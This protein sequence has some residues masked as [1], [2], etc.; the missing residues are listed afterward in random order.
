MATDLHTPISM[1][2]QPSPASS[3]SRAASKARSRSRSRPRPSRRRRDSSPAPSSSPP[4]LPTPAFSPDGHTDGPTDGEDDIVE[5]TLSPFDP[6]RITPTLHASLVSEILNLRREVESKTKAIDSLELSLDE[7]K[8]ENESLSTSLSQ[9]TRE[10]RSLKHQIQLLEGG[11]SSAM[12]ELARERDEAVENI[13]DVRKKLEQTQ[14]RARSREDEAERTQMLWDRDREAW[15]NERRNLERKVH[16]VEG[17]LKTVLSE[18]AAAQ[19]AGTLTSQHSENDENAKDKTKGSDTASVASSSQGRRRTSMTSVTTEEGENDANYHNVRYSVMSMAAGKA[20]SGLN[21][22]EELAFDEEDEFVSDEDETPASPEALPEERPMSVNSMASHSVASKARKILGLSL[23]STGS[24][25]ADYRALDMNNTAKALQASSVGYQDAGIQYSPPP[26]P[27]T[28]AVAEGVVP[29]IEITPT[30]PEM[31]DDADDEM[32]A[33]RMRDTSTL[34]IAVEMVS[35]ASQTIGS[36]PS[37]PWTPK[38]P[39]TPVLSAEPISEPVQMTS[40]STQT[41]PIPEVESAVAAKST[42]SPNDIQGQ[43]EVP[44]IAI[45]PP[46]SEPPSPRN[47]V[48]LPPQTK[49]VSI[50]T[51]FR[52]F[53]E[54][55]SIAIQTEEIRI[56]Q[57]PVKLPASLLPS[58]IPDLPTR[59]EILDAGAQPYRAP[60]PPPRSAKREQRSFTNERPVKPP[61]AQASEP[62]QAYPGNNDNGPLSDDLVSGL[63]RPF[64]SSSLFAGFEQLSDDDGPDAEERDVFT[65]D[66]LLNR[67][68]A[69]YTLRRGK[70]VNAKSSRPSLDDIGL[71]EIDEHLSDPESRPSDVGRASSRTTQ[72]SG[73]TASS[74]RQTG[75]RKMAMISS[76]TAAHQRTRARSPSEPSLDGSAGSSIA[77]PFPVPIRL[78]SRKIPLTGSDGPPSPT[79]STGRQFSDRGART[80]IARRPT[81]RRVRSAAAM[82]NSDLPERPETLSS[83]TRSASPFAPDSPS[84]RPPPMPFDDI[85][86]PRERRTTQKRAPHHPSVPSMNWDHERQDSTGGVQPTSVVDAIAQTMVGEWMFKYVRRRKSFGMGESKDNW[87]GRNPDEVSANITNSGVRHKRWVWLAPYEGSIMW[88]SKQPTSGPALLGK[89]GRKFAIQSVLDVKDDNPLPKG[90]GTSPPFSRSILVLTPQRALKFTALTIERHYVWLTALSFLSH[91]SMGLHDLAALP[92]APQEEDPSPPPQAALRR[93]PIRDSIRVAKGKPRPMPKGKRSFPSGPPVPE[94]PPA[95]LGLENLNMAADAPHVPRFSHHNHHTR[96]RSNTAP[97]P[98]ALHAIRSFSSQG[99]MATMPSSHSGTTVGSSEPYFSPVPPPP[100]PAGIGSGRSSIS[101]MSEASGR[102]SNTAASNMFD[103]GTVRMEAFIDHHAEQIN[104]PRPAPSI[105]PRHVRKTSSQWS[106]SQGRYEHDAP[107]FDDS[108]HSFRPDDPFRGF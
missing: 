23:Q 63:R 77:P 45:H 84:F 3:T 64:R 108:E 74:S 95:G 97:R 76:G 44:M 25:A 70:L 1:M 107:S 36:L 96:K 93:N 92:P 57:R 101:R 20:D 49:N 72:R 82:S 104:R 58:A 10:A 2:A 87:E 75:M 5:D 18:V 79:R 19:E 52:S 99:T 86:A 85:T 8:T 33:P 67:P 37:P 11:T 66:E 55:R 27:E 106:Q 61:R 28:K 43:I 12:T 7:S 105:R 78:S 39:D 40:A 24:I 88:S 26:S 41:D 30:G 34:T 15:E 47:S 17:R 100:L 16:V 60:V 6:R 91:S 51:N 94:I 14:K 81:L 62:V 48:V 21:L 22:A 29:A 54:G 31:E 50:Q 35:S 80:N 73:T 53:V 103:I 46:A 38:V 56:D 65:D 68:F 98:P 59:S 9:A 102:T 83:P 13:S 69:S 42:L 90:A 89:S 32:E 71:P 4:G